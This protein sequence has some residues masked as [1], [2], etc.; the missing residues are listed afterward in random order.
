MRWIG[1]LSVFSTWYARVLKEICRQS[2]P[3]CL[4]RSCG[5]QPGL[6]ADDVSGMLRAILEYAHTWGLPVVIAGQDIAIFFDSIDHDEMAVGLK[7]R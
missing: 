3:S 4:V 7:R 5:C 2:V 6:G 1:L